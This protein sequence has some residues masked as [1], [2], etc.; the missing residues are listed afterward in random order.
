MKGARRRV[1]DSEMNLIGVANREPPPEDARH[2]KILG[3]FAADE[4]I[5]N[6]QHN[7]HHV[8]REHESAQKRQI[9]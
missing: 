8:E 1:F 3:Q 4:V 7:Q 6:R 9:P 2:G 5:D